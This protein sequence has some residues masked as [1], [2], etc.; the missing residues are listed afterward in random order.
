MFRRLGNNIGQ[1]RR[2]KIFRLGTVG[3]LSSCALLVLAWQTHPSWSNFTSIS[4]SNAKSRSARD[5][6]SPQPIEIPVPLLAN[7]YNHR[8]ENGPPRDASSIKRREYG[9]SIPRRPLT[10]IAPFSDGSRLNTW[11]VNWERGEP[12]TAQRLAEIDEAIASTSLSSS[13]LFELARALNYLDG[14][15]VA[16]HCFRAALA[17]VPAV[18]GAFPHVS[19]TSSKALLADLQQTGALW[20]VEDYASLIKRFDIESSLFAPSSPESRRA[21][22][23]K[24]EAYYYSMNSAP[25]VAIVRDLW[26]RHQAANDLSESDWEEMHWVTAL[27]ERGANLDSTNTI[28]HLR[29][30]IAMKGSHMRPA[31]K[32][33]VA[34]LAERD[35][36]PEAEQEFRRYIREMSPDVNEARVV[37]EAVYRARLRL[38][39]EP[40]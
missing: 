22:H 25:A 3:A 21:D 26:T 35:M 5:P 12:T 33:L 4:I 29:A 40:Q 15:E 38:R 7:Y 8:F 36:L 11:L 31:T 20:R 24:A 14:D 28:E 17:R 18:G 13:T 16:D 2:G 19:A 37:F 9:N 32:L 34:C 6:T 1:G 10:I 27:Y 39:S 30:C 23:A